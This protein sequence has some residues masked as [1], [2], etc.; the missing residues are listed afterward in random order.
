MRD[1]KAGILKDAEPMSDK[2]NHIE[3]LKQ[4]TTHYAG[5]FTR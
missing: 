3:D 5:I 2:L 1:G 4:D